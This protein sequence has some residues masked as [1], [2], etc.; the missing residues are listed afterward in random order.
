MRSAPHPSGKG[1]SPRP[2]PTTRDDCCG[3]QTSVNSRDASQRAPD[4]T[5]RAGRQRYAV[6]EETPAPEREAAA[7]PE[8]GH[9]PPR[10]ERDPDSPLGKGEDVSLQPRN[11]SMEAPTTPEDPAATQHETAHD[12]QERMDHDPME[13][14]RDDFFPKPDEP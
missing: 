6:P 14:Q 11:E 3:D 4:E 2:P 9:D 7:E 5:V 1:A 10:L 13:P 8:P 12:E